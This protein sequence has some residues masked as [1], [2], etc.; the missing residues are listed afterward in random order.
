MESPK[1]ML[2]SIQANNPRG[3]QVIYLSDFHNV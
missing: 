3:T 1:E 2:R